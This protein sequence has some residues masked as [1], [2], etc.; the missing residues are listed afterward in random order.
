MASIINAS[1]SGVGG[2]I[3]TADNSGDLNI[4]SGGSTK[5]AVTSAGVAVTGT[6]SASG[7]VTVGATAAPAFS[8]YSSSYTSVA[9]ATNT[10]ITFNSESFDT[11]SAF[12]S[13]TNSR[14]TPQ[15]AGYYQF[16]ACLVS[17][18]TTGVSQLLFYKNG[19]AVSNGAQV[20]NNAGGV[21]LSV[22]DLIYLNGST[23]YVEVYMYQTQGSNANMGSNSA[24]YAFSG[25]LAR[26]A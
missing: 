18:A 15:V 17:L 1:T 12:D 5:I 11:A 21:I 4:Q 20:G 19:V 23:D 10:K 22:G 6:L 3:T 9:T 7:G 13:T 26:N 8:A 25:F 24:K 16:N 14:F 2:V